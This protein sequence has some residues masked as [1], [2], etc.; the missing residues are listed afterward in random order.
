[1][2]SI[3]ETQI[4]W[5]VVLLQYWTFFSSQCYLFFE[6]SFPLT[7]KELFWSECC[8]FSALGMFYVSVKRP[9]VELWNKSL[10]DVSD[11]AQVFVASFLD[12]WYEGREKLSKTSE[13]ENFR[14]YIL[15]SECCVFLFY[16]NTNFGASHLLF[17][18]RAFH[19]HAAE[20]VY[21]VCP[22]SCSAARIHQRTANNSK[23]QKERGIQ[24]YSLPGSKRKEPKNPSIP[25]RLSSE[26]GRHSKLCEKKIGTSLR[27]ASWSKA[28]LQRKWQKLSQKIGCGK[29]S[30]FE[31][32]IVDGLQSLRFCK[33][34]A[35]WM[36]A[37]LGCSGWLPDS[38][39]K[40]DV[41][42]CCD[43]K[44]ASKARKPFVGKK[45]FASGLRNR[46]GT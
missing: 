28:I 21:N 3:S 18:T 25:K 46:S 22:I 38:A 45:R 10:P 36:S 26:D 41:C 40:T 4:F 13:K 32:L 15:F 20:H 17:L 37:S 27:W 33:R 12:C 34:E 6:L 42:S 2:K 1:M 31:N 44:V 7:I 19:W 24:I 8:R 5:H 16:F 14:F 30:T 9:Q 35:E 11:S 43:L 39:I 29:K 23:F